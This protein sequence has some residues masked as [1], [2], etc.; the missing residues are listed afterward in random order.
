M[1]ELHSWS[2]EEPFKYFSGQVTYQK[3][4]EVPS[5]NPANTEYMLDFGDGTP[6]EKPQPLPN[7][8]MRAYLESPVREAA[9][10]FINGKSAGLVWHP[11]YRLNVTSLVKPGKNDIRI[12]VG[13]TAMNEMA[14]RALP[15][16]RLLND[17]YGERF[18][19]QD[20]DK[21]APLPSGILRGLRL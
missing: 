8:N 19:P 2:D 10:V 6:V 20:M 13:N 12:V 11:P 7:F 5:E 4:V 1:Q 3:T 9:Q 18:I 17:R 21:V 14:G 16:Y 15:D